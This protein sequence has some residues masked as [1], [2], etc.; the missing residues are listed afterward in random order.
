MIIGNK[1]CLNKIAAIPVVSDNGSF[2]MEGL[3]NRQRE[4]NKDRR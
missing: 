3:C 4:R 1:E 2:T